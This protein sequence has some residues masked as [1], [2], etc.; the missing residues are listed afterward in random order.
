MVNRT[1]GIAGD[2]ADYDAAIAAISGFPLADDYTF[3]LISNINQ[4]VN[5]AVYNIMLNG[6]TV[7]FTSNYN[8]ARLDDWQ[9]WYKVTITNPLVTGIFFSGANAGSGKFIYDHFYEVV[10]NNVTNA[11]IIQMTS[12]GVGQNTAVDCYNGYIDGK[13]NTSIVILFDSNMHDRQTHKYWNLKI[14]DASTGFFLGCIGSAS[15]VI[16]TVE[17]VSMYDMTLHGVWASDA[18]LI[19][20]NIVVTG[21]PG[22]NFKNDNLGFFGFS[23]LQNCACTDTSLTDEFGIE[24]TNSQ[25]EI[26]LADEFQSLDDTN[27]EFLNLKIGTSTRLGIYTSGAPQLGGTGINPVDAGNADIAGMPRPDAA[28]LYSIGCHEQ[29]YTGTGDRWVRFIIDAGAVYRGFKSQ[30]EPGELIGAT[31]GGSVFV[32]EQDVKDIGYDGAA[33]PV[34]GSRINTVVNCKLTCNF[35]QTEREIWSLA[36]PGSDY[37]VATTE[38]PEEHIELYR[39]RDIEN[40]DYIDNVVLIAEMMGTDIPVI[41]GVKNALVDSNMDFSLIDNDEAVIPITFKGHYFR[42]DYESDPFILMFPLEPTTTEVPTTS[43]TTTT[44]GP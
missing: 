10:N 41:C 1:I 21:N 17:N 9:N 38:V 19:G 27:Q 22:L 20:K 30:D 28:G 24:A 5:L 42:D 4:G 32:I 37:R 23:D 31:R 14:W 13:S 34:K 25:E 36:L 8:A 3:D 43:T 44:L 16:P 2:H 33:G 39:D 12:G 7:R 15:I 40:A 35:I 29:Q 11:L 6:H 26:V 18:P